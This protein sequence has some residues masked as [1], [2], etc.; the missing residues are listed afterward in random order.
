MFDKLIRNLQLFGLRCECQ[1]GESEFRLTIK[2]VYPV[3]AS[4]VS[5]VDEFDDI[6][7]EEDT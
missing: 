2:P 5:A 7:N 6:L 1:W 3:T 4:Q